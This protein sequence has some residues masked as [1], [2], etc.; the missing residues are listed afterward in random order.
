[1]PSI[2]WHA[3]E[4]V[5]PE[6]SR[7]IQPDDR[8][9]RRPGNLSTLT[10]PLPTRSGLTVRSRT[11]IYVET[12]VRCDMEKL[13]RLTQEPAQHQRWDLRFTEIDYLPR[14]D[15][16]APQRFRYAVRL[17]P[18]LVVA[19]EGVTLG[20]RS[21][22]DGS[23]TSALGFGSDSPLSPIREGRGYWR[24]VPTDDGIRFLTG[25]DYAPRWGAI[26]ELLDRYAVRPVMGWATAWSFDRL[27][28]WLETDQTPEVSRDQALLGCV[29]LARGRDGIPSAGRCLR[30]PPDRLGATEPATM[31]QVTLR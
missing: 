26:G 17:L 30:Q 6:A 15:P 21:A 28:L 19:G 9:R 22:S 7:P 27:R 4:G 18:G 24:Y 25:Y 11:P 14:A 29:G 8:L 10:I 5:V 20:D 12:R 1:M 3:H 13:W 2:A 23:R 16:T 31:N